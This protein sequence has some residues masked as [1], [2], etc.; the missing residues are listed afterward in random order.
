MITFF[1]LLGVAVVLGG[2]IAGMLLYSRH[3]HKS[4]ENQQPIAPEAPA[5][6]IAPE[7]PE[8]VAQSVIEET[9][10]V[11]ERVEQSE[12]LIESEQTIA[13]AETIE[14][15]TADEVERYKPVMY[16]GERRYIVIKY[17][18]SFTAKLIQSS[19]TTK[20]YYSQIKNC[21]LS[22][23]GVK[24]RISWKWETFRLG[25]KAL[26]KLRL[27]GKTLSIVMALDP[28]D[29]EN[30]KYRV[31]SLADVKTYADTPCLY[32]IKSD[33]KLR[34]CKELI[35]EL[36][37]K[38][39][40]QENPTAENIDYVSQ[41]PYEET[42]ALIER[43]LI[44]ELTD[45]DAQSGTMFKPSEVQLKLLQSEQTIADGDDEVTRYKSVVQDGKT[46]YIII[47]YSKSFTAKLIQSEEQ[48]KNYYSEIKNELLSYKGVKSR[49][50]W[51]WETFRKGRV[52]LA[53]L[54]L[55]GKTLS[56][57]LALNPANYADSKYAVK[58]ISDVKSFV[59][60]P[61]LYKIKNDRRLKY[62]KELIA[63]VMKENALEV[64]PVAERCDYVVEYPYDTT[65][66]LIERKLI[67]QLTEEEAQSGTQFK[68]RQSVTV[69]EA[70]DLMEDEVAISY[71]KQAEKPAITASPKR[72][73]K[74]SDRTKCGI[75]NIDT[76]SKYFKDGETVTL[77]EMI[78]RIPELNKKTTYIKVLARGTLDKRLNIYADSYSLQAVKMIV[79]TGGTA[80][81]N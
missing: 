67:K 21:L 26:A 58:D 71:V 10:A 68:P 78:K 6:P 7:Q 57:T 24:S 60:T 30:T 64:N 53:K 19:D 77:E 62:S 73:N 74:G 66:S 70:D 76:L 56:L 8:T 79:L 14:I 16:Q 44:K 12:P 63:D 37:L 72:I 2:V 51:K 45:E 40:V 59:E 5:E 28:A 52:A 48:T 80:I 49:I 35:A 23:K 54:R 34:Y 61:C 36:M 1:I 4:A 31:E 81:K 11:E 9:A 55:R 13:A 47:K 69:Q 25:R 65:E 17:S 27:R 20:D 38:N 33:R 46:R 39:G 43:G 15:Q 32:R 3:S 50:S 22:Y 42:D 18:K 41:H 75:V 29:Y